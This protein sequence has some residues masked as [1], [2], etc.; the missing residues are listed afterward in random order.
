LLL[1]LQLLPLL[2]LLQLLLVLLVENCLPSQ[3]G[4]G[5]DPY[6]QDHV[7]RSEENAG[8]S[9]ALQYNRQRV[10]AGTRWHR[11]QQR[12]RSL[13]LEDEEEEEEEEEEAAEEEEK[14]AHEDFSPRLADFP[15]STHPPSIPP[16]PGG[17]TSPPLGEAAGGLS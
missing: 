11:L 16:Q 6:R 2:L 7:L 8:P 12:V 10:C 1:L 13:S 5:M 17:P 3:V 15:C 9:G 14:V 4:F